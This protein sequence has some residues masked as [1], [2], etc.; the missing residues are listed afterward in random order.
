MRMHIVLQLVS[1]GQGKTV[2]RC[3][4]IKLRSAAS[5]WVLCAPDCVV[6]DQLQPH[7]A[8][9]APASNNLY[10]HVGAGAAKCL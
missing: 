7:D 9:K 8:H 5:R 6:A 4:V 1:F 10:T 2:Q 3:H